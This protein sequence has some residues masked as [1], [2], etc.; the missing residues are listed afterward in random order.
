MNTS[1]CRNP[2]WHSCAGGFP[3]QP[4]VIG[5]PAVISAVTTSTVTGGMSAVGPSTTP[6]S[7]RSNAPQGQRTAR[8]GTK[9]P[10]AASAAGSTFICSCW[11][12]CDQ[13]VIT[14]GTSCCFTLMLNRLTS[15]YV[16]QIACPERD[17][18]PHVLSNNGF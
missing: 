8:H 2:D 7:G 12:S 16:A 4:F 17:L 1:R 13:R 3:R 18:N 9:L 6:G 15:R 10:A 5:S 11:V 14:N